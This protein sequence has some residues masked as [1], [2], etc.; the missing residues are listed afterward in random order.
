MGVSRLECSVD[1][2]LLVLPVWQRLL[3]RFA[4]GC[5]SYELVFSLS[6][7]LVGPLSAVA[8]VAE[9]DYLYTAVFQRG[10]FC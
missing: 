9:E 10:D 7:V 4:S 8:C 5:I 2:W 3:L 1:C 6:V